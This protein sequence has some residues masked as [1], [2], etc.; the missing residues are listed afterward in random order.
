MTPRGTLVSSR[1]ISISDLVQLGLAANQFMHLQGAIELLRIQYADGEQEVLPRDLAGQ[2]WRPSHMTAQSLREIIAKKLGVH[3]MDARED[4]H[5]NGT[6]TRATLQEQPKARAS[7]HPT[8][9]PA[10]APAVVHTELPSKSIAKGAS[11]P[12]SAAKAIAP[13]VAVAAQAAA[14]TVVASGNASAPHAKTTQAGEAGPSQSSEKLSIVHL[15]AVPREGGKP[16]MFMCYWRDA[17]GPMQDGVEYK[18]HASFQACP[19]VAKIR[20]VFKSEIQRLCF[21]H[22]CKT[23]QK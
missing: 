23:K 11:A 10:R 9:K 6:P 20:V 1:S 5:R 15:R 13:A 12:R 7:Q 16:D 8:A 18:L 14:A 3:Q 4:G 2:L 22:K 17:P 21:V 19:C